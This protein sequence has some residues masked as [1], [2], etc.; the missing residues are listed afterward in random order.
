[1]FLNIY[2]YN[3]HTFEE[4]ILYNKICAVVLLIEQ[5]KHVKHVTYSLFQAQPLYMDN[6]Q[7]ILEG[8]RNFYPEITISYTESISGIDEHGILSNVSDFEI[9]KQYTWI[10]FPICR[11][12]KIYIS[13]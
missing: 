8:I 11:D 5:N 10:H 7:A 12:I 4:F 9:A 13:W 1:M 3:E 2:K 6:I